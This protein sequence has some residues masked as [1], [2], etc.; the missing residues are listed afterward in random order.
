MTKLLREYIRMSMAVVSQTPQTTRVDKTMIFE[1]MA[2]DGM[3]GH[4][5]GHLGKAKALGLSIQVII[6]IRM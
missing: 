2:P 1:F 4:G 6:H 3:T 5:Y